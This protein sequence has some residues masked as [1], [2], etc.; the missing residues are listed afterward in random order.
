MTGRY[1]KPRTGEERLTLYRKSLAFAWG[2]VDYNDWPVK[3]NSV[4]HL[5]L[6]EFGEELLE[7]INALKAQGCSAKDIAG[8]FYNPA[9]IYR[10]IDSAIY[11][12]RRNKYPLDQQ[13]AVTLE[14][15]SFV[16]VLKQG[17]EFNEDGRNIIY[18]DAQLAAV[19]D[20]LDGKTCTRDDSR[21]LHRFCGMIW[22]YTE[23]IFFRAHDVTKEIHGPYSHKDGRSNIIIKEYLNLHPSD[24]WP[25]IA[26]LPCKT[27]KVVSLYSENI[28][29]SIDA[30]NHLYHD[31]GSLVDNLNGYYIEVDG[32]IESA[33]RIKELV[34]DIGRAISEITDRVEQMTFNEKI[35]KYAEIFWFRKRPLREMRGKDW[36]LPL[37]VREKILAGE[38]NPRR[39]SRLPEEQVHRL[40]MLTI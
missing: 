28:K 40:A 24:I 18:N 23:A 22:A 1:M 32:K 14:L 29:Q 31:G 13:K 38:I 11:S 34:K 10:I 35:I 2:F 26:L 33:G 16:S 19:I 12:M 9:R 5:F 7:D 30:L 17:S 4:F 39:I 15:L 21:L 20:R 3:L 37:P 8:G 36:R 6:K 25:G 27:I